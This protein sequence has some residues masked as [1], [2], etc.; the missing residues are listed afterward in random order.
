MR[1]HYRGYVIR[2]NI[3][4]DTCWIERDGAFIAYAKDR[5]AARKIID[6]LMEV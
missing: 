5:V 3:I 1:E 6:Q 4:T 2:V